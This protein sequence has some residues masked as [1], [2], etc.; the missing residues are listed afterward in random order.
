MYG[1]FLDARIKN[2]NTVEFTLSYSD[3]GF[4][5]K[6]P[7]YTIEILDDKTL[8]YTSDGRYFYI[9]SNQGRNELVLNYTFIPK[10]SSEK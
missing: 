9:N 7:K 3:E 2:K 10:S 8:K 5:Y 1:E 4:T 6:V